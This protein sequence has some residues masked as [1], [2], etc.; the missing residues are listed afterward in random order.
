M[1][2]RACHASHLLVSLP[3]RELQQPGQ[4][5]AQL[6]LHHHQHMISCRLTSCTPIVRI[7][8][9]DLQSSVALAYLERADVPEVEVDIELHGRVRVP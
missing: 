8:S 5:R 2:D 1:G 4:Q 6:H 3:L 9:K 7:A